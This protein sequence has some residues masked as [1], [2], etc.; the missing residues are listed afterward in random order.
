M[1]GI[2]II[3]RCKNEAEAIGETLRKVFGQEIDLAREV[4]LVDSGSTDRTLEI[5]KKYP[6]RV[7]RIPPESFSF[8]YALN[9]GIERAEG[10]II[11]NISAHCAPVNEKWL[12]EL[13]TPIREGLADAVYGRQVPVKGR[14]PF[15][16]VSLQKHFPPEER[17]RGRVP[18]SNA[19]CAFR[20]KM[21]EEVR[22]DEDLP[23]WE[24]Y[25]WY[26]LL[27]DRHRFRYCPKAAVFHTHRFSLAE[28]RRR[29]RNDGK[30]FR[31]FKDKYHIDLIGEAYPSGRAKGRLLV[32]DMREHV[33][34]FARNGYLKYIFSAPVVRF[35]AFRSYRDGYKSIK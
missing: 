16:E 28:V 24:D 2:S 29:S 9:F 1:D 18:F 5:A 4:V 31:I 33:K 10:D 11:V 13:V 32:N 15:E 21:W 23:S 27:K 7:Y 17:V 14:N 25:L 12:S 8:G 6:V 20:K 26:L 35:L 30:A 19:N 22:F 34:F 3:I